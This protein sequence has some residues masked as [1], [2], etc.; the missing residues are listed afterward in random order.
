MA[1][2][3]SQRGRA[4]SSPYPPTAEGLSPELTPFCVTLALAEGTPEA[5]LVET[6]N[7]TVRSTDPGKTLVC[8]GVENLAVIVTPEVVLVFDRNREESVREVVQ[9]L[10]EMNCEELL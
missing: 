7:C 5:V 6:Q 4:V 10:K 2:S 8:Y 3:S 1:G 9:K